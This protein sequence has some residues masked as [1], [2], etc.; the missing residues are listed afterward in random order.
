M[1]RN[2]TIG[3][4]VNIAFCPQTNAPKFSLSLVRVCATAAVCL[5]RCL[6]EGHLYPLFMAK[7][8]SFNNQWLLYVLYHPL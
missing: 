2:N 3:D 6:R 7:T 1:K 8:N 4:R 5:A